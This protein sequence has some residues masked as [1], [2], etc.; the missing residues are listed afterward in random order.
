MPPVKSLFPNQEKNFLEQQGFLEAGM[1][2]S[3]KY[4]ALQFQPRIV[5]VV[6][7]IALVLQSSVLF[8]LLS[9]ALAVG[10]KWPEK[11]PFD[12]LYRKTWGKRPGAEAMPLSP[13]PRRFAQGMAA[14]MTFLIG[15]FLLIRRPIWAYFLEL[16]MLAALVALI[17][18]GFCFGA[19][20]YHAIKGRMDVAKRTLPWA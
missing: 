7:L 10:A 13:P 18:T 14:G 2:C 9:V 16:M 12:A 4:G 19:V 20:V 1:S 11:N 15:L 17:F 8:L 5:G 6:F 3:S